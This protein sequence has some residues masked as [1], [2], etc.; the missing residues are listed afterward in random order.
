MPWIFS[1]I[2]KKNTKV[3]DTV[4]S[5][6]RDVGTISHLGNEEHILNIENVLLIEVEASYRFQ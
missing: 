6:N 2:P 5:H 3:S 4:K 1:N